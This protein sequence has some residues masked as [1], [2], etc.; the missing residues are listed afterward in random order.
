M[1]SFFS[2]LGSLFTGR[3]TDD[4]GSS[5]KEAVREINGLTVVAAPIKE[6][7][8]YRIAGRIEKEAEG[9]VMVRSFIRADVFNSPDEAVEFTFRKAEQ[10]IQQNGSTLFQDGAEARNV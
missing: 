3:S 9:K 1:A 5:G 4:G 7:G 10:I 2:R 8:T 6:G